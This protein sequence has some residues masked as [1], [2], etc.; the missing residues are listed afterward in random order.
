MCLYPVPRP[1][2]CSAQLVEG[3]AETR[4]A[5]CLPQ[6]VTTRGLPASRVED[7]KER[8][9]SRREHAMLTPN[10][11]LAAPSVHIRFGIEQVR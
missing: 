10:D 3:P 9:C 11:E 5:D 4:R 6:E 7:L 2:Q 8:L 1:G